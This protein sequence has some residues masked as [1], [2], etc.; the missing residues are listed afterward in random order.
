ME[1]DDF[2]D[3]DDDADDAVL[4]LARALILV[5]MANAFLIGSILSIFFAALTELWICKAISMAA[6][7]AAA[8][9]A[10]I[11]AANAAAI[12]IAQAWATVKASRKAIASAI[13]WLKDMGAPHSHLA[14]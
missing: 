9:M 5:I 8:A 12:G 10:A 3:A 11:T 7:F 13:S 1:Y 4:R 2:D 14:E 6:A